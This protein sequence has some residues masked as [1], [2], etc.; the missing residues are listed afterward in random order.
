M[1]KSQDAKH[2]DG[3]LLATVLLPKKTGSLSLKFFIKLSRICIYTLKTVADSF[4]IEICAKG[5]KTTG[6]I[7]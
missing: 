3:L 1:H 7:K 6:E 2:R 4:D 5:A